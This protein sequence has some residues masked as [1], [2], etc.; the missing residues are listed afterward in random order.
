MLLGLTR[1]KKTTKR[2]A[3]H[4]SVTALPGNPARMAISKYISIKPLHRPIASQIFGVGR[5]DEI[6][7]PVQARSQTFIKSGTKP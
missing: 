5:F 4:A 6:V 3:F 7:N 1:T 2:F